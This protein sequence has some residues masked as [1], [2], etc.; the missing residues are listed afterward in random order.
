MLM[1]KSVAYMPTESKLK[2]RLTESE[3]WRKKVLRSSLHMTLNGRTTQRTRRG[4]SARSKAWMVSRWRPRHHLAIVLNSIS[5]Y[6]SP[7]PLIILHICGVAR[8]S[9]SSPATILLVGPPTGVLIPA[10]PHTAE[11]GKCGACLLTT[12]INHPRITGL[13]GGRHNHT[14]CYSEIAK[15]ILLAFM[16]QCRDLI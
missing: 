12:T 7:V 8:S 14:D 11:L 2:R 3:P 5:G 4:S 1:D 6:R 15:Q 9:V 10:L 16:F 13:R